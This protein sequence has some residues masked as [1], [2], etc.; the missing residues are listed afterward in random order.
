MARAEEG[1]EATF[2]LTDRKAYQEACSRHCLRNKSKSVFTL[3]SNPSD[4]EKGDDGNGRLSPK[5]PITF[6]ER[7]PGILADSP[8]RVEA[9]CNCAEEKTKDSWVSPENETRP[10]GETTREV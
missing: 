6:V 10:M 7:G 8:R 4:G 1:K 5:V 3:T 2:P 9:L